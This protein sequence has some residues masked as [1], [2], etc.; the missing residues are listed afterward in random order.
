MSSSGQRHAQI[1]DGEVDSSSRFA[2]F[3]ALKVGGQVTLRKQFMAAD[4]DAFARLSGDF[5]PLHVDEEFAKRTRLRRRIAHGMLSAAYISSLVGTHIPGPGALWLHQSFEF[6][7]PIFV[8]DEVEFLLRVEHK[9]QAT[10]TLLICV[11]AR[12]QQ[13]VLV[14]KGQ[15]KVMVLEEQKD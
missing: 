13:G 4:I 11:E 15:G 14:M 6:L 1:V 9:S 12:N 8:S 3:E 2:D 7:K 10:R 5:N